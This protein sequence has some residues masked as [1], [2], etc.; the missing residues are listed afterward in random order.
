MASGPPAIP[1]SASLSKRLPP[2]AS[3]R[4]AAPRL[5]ILYISVEGPAVCQAVRLAFVREQNR[6]A[7]LRGAYVPG[8]GDTVSYLERRKT[9]SGKDGSR[10]EVDE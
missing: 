4:P 8:A 1:V 6:P 9:R 3:V 7:F 2:P 10:K 5:F